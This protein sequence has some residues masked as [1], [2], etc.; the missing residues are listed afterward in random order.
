MSVYSIRPHHLLC[1][2]FF[3]G[4]GYSSE[5]VAHTAAVLHGLQQGGF[6]T[7]TEGADDICRHC[8]HNQNGICRTQD[9]VLRYDK[10]VLIHC[11]LRPGQIYSWEELTNRAANSIILSGRLSAVCGD[12]EW[13][14][15]CEKAN[16]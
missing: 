10:A 15:L 2:S 12:C 16:K 11:R 14:S 13:Q 7:I 6:A 9:K 3:E 4:K 8:P 5:F 1:L